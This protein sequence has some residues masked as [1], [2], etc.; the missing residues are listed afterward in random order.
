VF[1]VFGIFEISYEFYNYFSIFATN[2]PGILEGI[3][4]N[5]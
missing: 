2:A 3:A 5:L 4:L 1:W